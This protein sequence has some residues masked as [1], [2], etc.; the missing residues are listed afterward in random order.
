MVF[1]PIYIYANAK[2]IIQKGFVVK[3]RVLGIPVKFG[4]KIQIFIN[5][6]PIIYEINPVLA[7]SEDINGEMPE[8]YSQITELKFDFGYV[9]NTKV[10]HGFGDSLT[11]IGGIGKSI[12]MFLQLFSVFFILLYII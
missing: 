11:S 10:Y 7:E 5:M 8:K 1:D 3:E 6:E 9:K 12:T 2:E 4:D